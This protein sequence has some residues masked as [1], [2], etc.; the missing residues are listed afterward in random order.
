MVQ[1]PPLFIQEKVHPKVLIDDLQRRTKEDREDAAT[2]S[3]PD[4]FADFNG[5]PSEDARTEFYQHD[6]NWSTD[7]SWRQPAGDGFARGARGAARQGAV[8]LYR[9][10]IRH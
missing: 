5:L 9:P 1:A 3:Q 7:D 6:A 10:A 8:H 2:E 4:L